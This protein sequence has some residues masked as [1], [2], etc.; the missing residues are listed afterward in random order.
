MKC[1]VM[2]VQ[3]VRVGDYMYTVLAD[4]FRLVSTIHE[5]ADSIGIMF[6]NTDAYTILKKETIVT[7]VR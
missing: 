2:S 5:Y 7:I 1:L 4:S 6:P 3:E